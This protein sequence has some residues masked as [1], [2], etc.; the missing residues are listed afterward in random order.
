MELQ[1]MWAFLS[2]NIGVEITGGIR[3]TVAPKRIGMILYNS[4]FVDINATSQSKKN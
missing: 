3:M 4:F 1:I 2:K